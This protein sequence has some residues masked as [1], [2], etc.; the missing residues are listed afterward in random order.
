MDFFII[1]LLKFSLTKAGVAV[2]TC[3]VE[4]AAGA[5]GGAGPP[6]LWASDDAVSTTE[7]NFRALRSFNT[8]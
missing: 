6:G 8:L 4:S 3:S 2:G 5:G 7:S 1:L